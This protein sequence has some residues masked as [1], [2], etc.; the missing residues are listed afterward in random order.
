[1][2]STRDKNS[3]GNYSLEQRAIKKSQENLGYYYGPN[4]H[5]YRP[6]MP[7]LYNFSRVPADVLSHNSVDIES[8]LWGINSTN[9][10]TPQPDVVPNLKTL[11]SISFF[12]RPVVVKDPGC[13]K[14]NTDRPVIF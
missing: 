3:K 2:A 6:A 7:E 12:D 13:I 9:L 4:G 10:V 1:M 5:A 8:S 11:P 14:K